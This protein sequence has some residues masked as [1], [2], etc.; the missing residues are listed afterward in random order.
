M[1][2]CGFFVILGDYD[3]FSSIFVIF[4]LDAAFLCLVKCYFVYLFIYLFIYL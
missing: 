4:L 2:I 1:C 3:G